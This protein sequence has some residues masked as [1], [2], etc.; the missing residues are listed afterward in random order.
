MPRK[1][2]AAVLLLV[3]ALTAGA[4]DAP[5]AKWVVSWAGSVQGPYRSATLRRSPT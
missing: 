4:Q 3:V 5:K 2:I 1:M